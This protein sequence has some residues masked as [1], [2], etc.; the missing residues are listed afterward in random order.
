V[1][2]FTFKKHGIDGP[3]LLY[4]MPAFRAL[5]KFIKLDIS[6][7]KI[8]DKGFSYLISALSNSIGSIS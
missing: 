2:E 7:N 4:L 1:S 3:T 6:Y 8:T 5:K